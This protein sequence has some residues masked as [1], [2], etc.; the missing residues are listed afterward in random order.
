MHNI[1]Q[2]FLLLNFVNTYT[3][4]VL[5]FL[6]TNNHIFYFYLLTE[7]LPPASSQ[8]EGWSGVP[9]PVPS[10]SQPVKY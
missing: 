2:I 10:P 7:F 9:S 6:A 8:S 3:V 4:N 1:I 5:F